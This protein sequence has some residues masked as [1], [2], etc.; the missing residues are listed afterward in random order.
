MIIQSAEFVI[1][2]TEIKNFPKPDL[3][4]YA[5]LGRS[6]V[7][8]SSLINMLT[9]KRQLAKTSSTPGKTRQINFFLINE[10]WYLAD[11]PGI[12]YAKVSKTIKE[13]WEQ[14]ISGYLLKRKN[15]ISVFYLIDC[16]IKPQKTDLDFV[17]WMGKYQIPFILIF[18]KTDK[19]SGPQLDKNLSIYKKELM[20]HW[21]ELPLIIISSSKT[22][23]GKEDILKYIEN[24]NAIFIQLT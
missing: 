18:T 10:C 22:K 6:N 14:M 24:N 20:K 3:P 15:L 5:F 1:T 13:K 21:E 16:R 2:C 17:D 9:N 11:L 19:I 4:E 8:K 7:G 23:S 12:G